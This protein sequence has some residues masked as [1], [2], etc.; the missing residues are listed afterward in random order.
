MARSLGALLAAREPGTDPADVVAAWGDGAVRAPELVAVLHDPGS[1]AGE[2]FVAA[3]ALASWGEAA[4]FAA[5]CDAA[6]RG[7]TV[8]WYAETLDG[9]YSRDATFDRLA[10]ACAAGVDAAAAA[11]TERERIAALRAL[12][13]LADSECFPDDLAWA[14][15]PAT[16]PHVAD[17]LERAVLRGLRRLADGDRPG[18]P[19]GAQLAELLTP[20]AAV[21]EPRAVRLGSEVL[22]IDSSPGVCRR[23][24]WIVSA[25]DGPLSLQFG[26][27]LG[28]VGGP[29]AMSHVAEALRRREFRRAR[30]R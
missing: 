11:G 18:F 23:L 2:R 5:V 26:E 15:G 12:V 19:L 14:L 17:D 9:L 8:D 16:M 6:A 22:G 4:G 3:W 29:R 1:A 10:G 24:S 7:P 21:D 25:G 28:L 20:L 30:H 13:G 27:Q